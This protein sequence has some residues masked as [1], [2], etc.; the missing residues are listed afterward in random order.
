MNSVAALT[1]KLKQI[2]QK[3]RIAKQIEKQRLRIPPRI[4]K[5][6]AEYP[7]VT[8][9]RKRGWTNGYER[10][11]MRYFYKNGISVR[12]IAVKFAV[13]SLTVYRYTNGLKK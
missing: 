2:A 10:D 4:Q 12:A 7:Q 8:L 13:C 9:S 11:N 3:L 6:F 5:E 1:K